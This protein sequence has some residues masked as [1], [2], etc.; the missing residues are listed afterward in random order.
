MLTVV[1]ASGRPSG[2]GAA[3]RTMASRIRTIIPR[4]SARRGYCRLH[5]TFCQLS[6]QMSAIGQLP[7]HMQQASRRPD[8]ACVSPAGPYTQGVAG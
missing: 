6:L 7:P 3:P 8:D 4:Q 5:R 1:P 2:L